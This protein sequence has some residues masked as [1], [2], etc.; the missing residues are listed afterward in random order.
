MAKIHPFT[1]VHDASASSESFTTGDVPLIMV[2][3]EPDKT[4]PTGVTRLMFEARANGIWMPVWDVGTRVS[5]SIVPNDA[6]KGMASSLFDLCPALK[7]ALCIRFV[8]ADD[9]NDEVVCDIE[10]GWTL[11]TSIKEVRKGVLA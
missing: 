7:S 11:N 8:L 6:T 1:F 10:A 2:Y 3:I 4:L 5:M 9:S